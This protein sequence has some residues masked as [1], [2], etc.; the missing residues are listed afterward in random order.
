MKRIAMLVLASVTLAVLSTQAD[1]GAEEPFPEYPTVEE[2]PVVGH[3]PAKASRHGPRPTPTW[4]R[5]TK[6]NL[7]GFGASRIRCH[8]LPGRLVG[9]KAL[10]PQS[11]GARLIIRRASH[12]GQLVASCQTLSGTLTAGACFDFTVWVFNW[13]ERDPTVPEPSSPAA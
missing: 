9:C 10:I 3:F 4:V 6:R 7:R 8:G 1:A 12:G 11:V 13:S 5:S 2:V